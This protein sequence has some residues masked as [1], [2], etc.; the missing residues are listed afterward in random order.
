[1]KA[2]ELQSKGSSSLIY[3]ED[4]M[5]EIFSDEDGEEEEY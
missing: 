4:Y 2:N 5:H 1:M 3:D